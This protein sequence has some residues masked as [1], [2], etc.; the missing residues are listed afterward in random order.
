MKKVVISQPR[1]LPALN[2]LQRLKNADVF[3]FLV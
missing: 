1:Y 3:V 2:Y